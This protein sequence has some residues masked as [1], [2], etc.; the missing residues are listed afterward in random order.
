MLKAAT[1]NAMPG[2]IPKEAFHH[3]QPRGAGRSEVEN[4]ARMLTLP[5]QHQGMLVGAVIVPNEVNGFLR[6]RFPVNETRE[7]QPFLM[8]MPALAGSQYLSTGRI[9]R[10]KQRGGAM[11]HVVVR[12]RAGPPALER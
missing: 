6:R 10:G 8:P 9:Q 1:P 5:I 7:F 12:T 4:K 11:T 2:Q 3:V